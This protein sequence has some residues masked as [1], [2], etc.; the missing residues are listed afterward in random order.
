M[1]HFKE[2]EVSKVASGTKSS[3]LQSE[4]KTFFKSFKELAFLTQNLILLSFD[5]NTYFHEKGTQRS[6]ILLD[7]LKYSTHFLF[8]AIELEFVRAIIL[9]VGFTEVLVLITQKVTF[10]INVS[11]I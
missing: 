3:S 7:H 5:F 6:A 2:S 10:L 1:I 4:A 9:E 11:P 8:S